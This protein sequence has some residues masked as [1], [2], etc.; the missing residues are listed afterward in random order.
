MK[1]RSKPKII[2]AEQW[3]GTDEHAKRLGLSR[4]T[5]ISGGGQKHGWCVVTL[6]GKMDATLGDWIITGIAG[7][8]YPCKPDI[9]A[10]S[11]E[12]LPPPPAGEAAP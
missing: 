6:E 12:P 11:Y 8:R 10:K 3:D 4:Y 5:R 7:E 9:F 2:D 1:Y